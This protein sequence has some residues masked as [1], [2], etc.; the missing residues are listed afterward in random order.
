[1]DCISEPS[2]VNPHNLDSP[3]KDV[4]WP[5]MSSRNIVEDDDAAGESDES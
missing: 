3:T 4:S 2:S 5:Q 1:M